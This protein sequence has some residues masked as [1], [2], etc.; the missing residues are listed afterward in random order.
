[1]RTIPYL[2]FN[3][4]TEEALKFYKQA[5][6]AEIVMLMRFGEAPDKPPM[7][8]PPEKIMHAEMRI[9]GTEI[10]ASD[11]ACDQTQQRFD[12]MSMALAVKTEAEADRVFNALSDGGEVRMPLGKTF[13]SPRFGMCADRFGLGWMVM[14]EQPGQPT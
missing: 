3:G 6:G 12:G 5:I 7:P 4:R 14:T 10:Y 8:V 2:F 1:M 13:W 9:G 11:G